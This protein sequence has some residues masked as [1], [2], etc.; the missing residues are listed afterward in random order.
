MNIMIW[1]V[2]FLELKKYWNDPQYREAIERDSL[3]KLFKTVKQF[4]PTGGKMNIKEK[5]VYPDRSQLI[6]I[7]KTYPNKCGKYWYE[8]IMRPIATWVIQEEK[9]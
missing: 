2:S 4:Q 8:E 3:N 6:I 7:S 9:K 5:Q 1:Y